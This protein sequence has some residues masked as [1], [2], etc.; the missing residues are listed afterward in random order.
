MNFFVHIRVLNQE[1][2]VPSLLGS[3]GDPIPAFGGTTSLGDSKLPLK[4][5][6]VA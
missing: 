3:R 6:D 2:A 5:L 4:W 1:C